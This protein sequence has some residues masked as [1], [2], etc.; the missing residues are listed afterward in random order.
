MGLPNVLLDFQNLAKHHLE[1]KLEIVVLNLLG[2]LGLRDLSH[3]L[4]LLD[5]LKKGLSALRHHRHLEQLLRQKMIVLLM[6]LDLRY[7]FLSHHRQLKL[8]LVN[9]VN[10]IQKHRVLLLILHRLHGFRPSHPRPQLKQS[11][12]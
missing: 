4:I 7:G 5:W 10:Y 1:L 11:L 12:L 6:L 3:L 9:L 2:L 8:Q